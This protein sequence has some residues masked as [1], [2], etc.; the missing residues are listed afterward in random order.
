MGFSRAS[1]NLLNKL[2]PASRQSYKA[3]D[4]V[5]QSRLTD[6][7]LAA[8]KRKVSNRS[9]TPPNYTIPKTPK[10]SGLKWQ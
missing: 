8:L 2:V 3:P 7:Q 10:V 4:E 6:E 1:K 5:L 9:T